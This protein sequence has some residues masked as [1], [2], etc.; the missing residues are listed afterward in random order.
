MRMSWAP[1]LSTHS[2]MAS[3]AWPTPPWP[4]VGPPQPCG[5]CCRRGPSPALSSASTLVNE[6][7]RGY[8][9]SSATPSPETL[10]D[11]GSTL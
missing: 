9:A 3:R 8:P 7:P 1:I 11:R 5:A 6:E 2:L 10:T 4:W